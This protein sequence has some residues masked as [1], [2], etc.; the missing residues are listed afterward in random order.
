MATICASNAWVLI[1]PG[2]C[3]QIPPFVLCA[4]AF[5]RG[6]GLR[7]QTVL[8]VVL[9]LSRSPSHE[10]SASRSARS[11]QALIQCRCV[12]LT[13]TN[14]TARKHG[15]NQ[16]SLLERLVNLTAPPVPIPAFGVLE[17]PSAPVLVPPLP[18]SQ[19]NE[20]EQEDV[21]SL[22]SSM[23]EGE[24][25]EGTKD[26]SSLEGSPSETYMAPSGPLVD[27]LAALVS[28]AARGQTVLKV[29]LTLSRS[30]SHEPSAS[31]SARSVQALI[32]C[33][34]VSLTGTNDTA[35]KHGCNQ[36]SLLERLVN[37]TAPPV[38][39]PAFGVLENP[40]APVLV[41]PLPQSQLN[42]EEQEDVVSL[43]SSME[44]GE[45]EEGTK[46]PSSLE[47]SPSETYMAPS[48]PLVDE[49]AALVSRAAA[50][51]QIP[52]TEETQVR[53]LVFE[54][55]VSTTQRLITVQGYGISAVGF[56]KTWIEA[57]L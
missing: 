20:E 16:Q 22:A 32:Q 10:P 42:E 55:S 8:K 57:L 44:E 28:R 36:Q 39:I 21:V 37:L 33:R 38:P 27:E 13:G 45:F 24:F 48:G 9:T 41:P 31:R 53:R 11:V 40:S 23:E 47:G 12:S 49:L 54:T 26:P 17:N 34:C 14:D 2:D 18:Q 1:M 52:W 35:R 56:A 6:S 51:V 3:W 29:V 19:L 46:D 25:E 50:R 43:A 5:K 4:L 7:G 15:C 30:P